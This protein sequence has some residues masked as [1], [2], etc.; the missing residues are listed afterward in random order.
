MWLWSEQAEQQLVQR[1]QQ[2]QRLEQAK[3]QWHRHAQGWLAL[4]EHQHVHLQQYID[5][6]RQQGRSSGSIDD[7]MCTYSCRRNKLSS[8]MVN[9]GNRSSE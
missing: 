8:N 7:D 3:V 9:D 5:W 6:G 2:A 1:Q 4:V